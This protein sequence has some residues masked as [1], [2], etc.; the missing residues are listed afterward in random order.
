MKLYRFNGS[1]TCRPVEMFAAEA[2]IA[3]DLV[4][5]D[6]M[7]GEHMGPAYTA[8]NPVQQV[9]TLEDGDFRL[10]ENSAILKYLAD[11]VGSLAYPKELKARARVNAQMDFFNTSLSREFCYG[12][13]YP[14]IL[15]HVGHENPVVQ[16]AVL[17]R[18]RKNA[19]KYLRVLNDHMLTDEGPYLGGAEPNLADYMGVSY[20][21]L[22]E[23]T[24]FD[25]TPYPRVQRWIAAMKARP[26]WKAAHGGWEAWRDYVLSK[27]AA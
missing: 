25:Y 12:H 19:E 17:E 3:L 8:K 1:T 24:R 4:D 22:G 20:A 7:K 18:C 14:Q 9:P 23:M 15:P 11:L 10:V 2:G 5:V 27:S 6:L 26:G 13:V 16:Q 21:T